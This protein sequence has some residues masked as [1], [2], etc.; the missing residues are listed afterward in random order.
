M[1]TDSLSQLRPTL[2]ITVI[3]FGGRAAWD[4][5]G[6]HQIVC[7]GFADKAAV[8]AARPLYRYDSDGDIGC[9]CVQSKIAPDYSN[10]PYRNRA[11]GPKPLSWPDMAVGRRLR[12]RL[13][14]KPSFRVGQKDSEFRGRR[15]AMTKEDD[16]RD[17]LMR[18]GEANGFRPQLFSVTAVRW[19]DE[20]KD[21]KKEDLLSVLF[22]GFLT[23]TEPDRLTWAVAN[24]IGPQKSY[25]FGLLSLAEE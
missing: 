10:T 3:A 14:A 21:H 16:Q 17:W 25:G 12:F 23:V 1:Q 9:L 2:Y 13:L 15:I 11:I 20:K 4:F 22:D 18:K 8:E 5:Y 6:M 19:N 7:Q 24:G